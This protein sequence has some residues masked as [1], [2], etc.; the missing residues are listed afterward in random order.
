MSQ[1]VPPDPGA[2][3]GD[4]GG[5][6]S[7]DADAGAADRAE[8]F[9]R[10]HGELHGLAARAMSDERGAHTLQPTALL[11]EAWLRLFAGDAGLPGDRQRFLTVVTKVM[12]QVLVDHARARS[13]IKRGGA[14]ASV[15][16]EVAEGLLADSE[17]SGAEDVDVVELDAAL[18]E[19]REVSSRQADIV[20]LRFFGGLGVDE[21][22]S[23]LGTSPRT[24]A[25]DWRFA[26]AWLM[27]RIGDRA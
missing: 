10:L 1:N 11:N 3:S 26:R 19:L 21:T 6:G 12:R 20:E 8:L 16:I 9:Q 17:G 14:F 13:R 23:A 24:V 4:G 18:D 27:R 15:S 22:A 7:L 5:D 25:R 2:C